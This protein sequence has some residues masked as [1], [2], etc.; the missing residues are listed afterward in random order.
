MIA[1]ITKTATFIIFEAPEERSSG[2][3]GYPGRIGTGEQPAQ[4]SSKID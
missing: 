4:P 1:H 3:S 2:L